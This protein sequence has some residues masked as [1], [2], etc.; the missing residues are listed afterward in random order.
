MKINFRILLGVA[1]LLPL[2]INSCTAY[3]KVPYVQPKVKTSSG[4]EV[5]IPSFAHESTIRFQ[6]DDALNITV[7]VVGEQSLATDF[8]LSLVPTATS[9]NSATEVSGGV[10]R[11]A[12][13]IDKEGYIDFPVLGKIKASGYT[14]QE[15]EEYLKEKIKTFIPGADAVISVRLASFRIYVAGEV[16]SAGEK[17]VSR[18]RMNILQALSLAGDM[19][20]YGRRDNVMVLREMPDGSLRKVYLDLT[21]EKVINSPDFYV[22][23]NDYIYVE[24]NKVRSQ[25]ADV[26]PQVGVAVSVGSFLISMV[27]FVLLLSGR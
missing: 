13:L 3:K 6:P 12:Y 5:I 2:F 15:F 4:E 27:T 1:I 14:R 22:R 23:Q 7:N 16:A 24:P 11:Q 8:N 19:T 18:D 10:G 17:S 20:I 9:E 25:A 21:D 26:S